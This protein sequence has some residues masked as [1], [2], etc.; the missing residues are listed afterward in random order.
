MCL[1]RR[2]GPQLSISAKLRIMGSTL[3]DG[4]P[5]ELTRRLRK[6]VYS[7]ME[8]YILRRDVTIPLIPRPQAK[9][10]INVRPLEPGDLPQVAAERPQ[11]LLLGILTSGL[12]QC[13]VA[14]TADNQVCYMQ[15]L[16]APAHRERLRAFR[17][18]DFYCFD[19][20]TV[21]LEFAYTF[22]RF[23][24]LGIMAPAMAFIAE[25]GKGA[26]W[27]VTYV[28]RSNIPSLRG[29]HSAGFSPYRLC[30]DSWRLFRLTQSVMEPT[31]LEPF[32][33]A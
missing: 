22:R 15:W 5:L 30:C 31:S 21:V 7:T 32:W 18:R 1:R 19:D 11:G 14:L 27:A 13:Y 17:F 29:C 4:D 12:P 6:L 25:Q 8:S 16:V 3:K 9:I 28:D 23:R 2:R 10:S 24:G 20:D 26:H 33:T